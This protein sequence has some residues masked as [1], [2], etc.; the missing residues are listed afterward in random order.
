MRKRKSAQRE[1]RGTNPYLAGLIG[2]GIFAAIIFF[3]SEDAAMFR[4]AI[5]F[6]A[7][8]AGLASLS[9]FGVVRVSKS[10]PTV[11]HVSPHCRKGKQKIMLRFRA[12]AKG[13]QPCAKCHDIKGMGR[14]K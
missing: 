6:L 2:V 14:K 12:K 10:S 7:L 9:F 13:M 3:V 5:P 4:G 1:F 8:L 11:Y